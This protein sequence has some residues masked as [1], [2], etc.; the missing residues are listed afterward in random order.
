MTETEKIITVQ[1]GVDEL[2]RVYETT[3]AWTD[4]PE[5]LDRYYLHRRGD[6]A[7]KEEDTKLIE[8]VFAPMEQMLQAGVGEGDD[9]KTTTEKERTGGDEYHTTGNVTESR[10]FKRR[11][12]TARVRSNLSD[13]AVGDD[14]TYWRGLRGL[15][16]PRVGRVVSRNSEAASR[17]G[18]V[19]SVEDGKLNLIAVNQLRVRRKDRRG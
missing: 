12:V 8:S 9:A 4:L 10:I 13:S 19:F 7:R 17:Y 5:A 2:D 15:G 14:L 11:K 3:D 18:V 6:Y 1:D 16:Y